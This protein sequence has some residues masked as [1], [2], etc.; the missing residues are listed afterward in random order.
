MTQPA[1][2]S[3]QI[4]QRD[5]KYWQHNS[6]KGSII[7]MKQRPEVQDSVFKKTKEERELLYNLKLTNELSR[8]KKWGVD[9]KK[10]LN[11]TEPVTINI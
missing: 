2:Q 7:P 9:Y 5:S 11:D 1:E 4:E 10:Y 6:Y 8:K 3:I